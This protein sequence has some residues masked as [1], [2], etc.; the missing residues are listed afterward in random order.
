L[1]IYITLGGGVGFKDQSLKTDKDKDK[2]K[3]KEREEDKN[4]KI[5]L[6]CKNCDFLIS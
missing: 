6:T 5:T 1:G 3:D 4:V 2:D